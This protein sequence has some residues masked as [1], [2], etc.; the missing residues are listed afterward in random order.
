[1]AV[2]LR[3]QWRARG[4]ESSLACAA[5]RGPRCLAR[6]TGNDL[7]AECRRPA[8]GPM[9]GPQRLCG[10]GSLRGWVD[11]R[12]EDIRFE[13]ELE[14]AEEAWRKAGRDRDQL[15]RGGRLEEAIQDR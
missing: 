11:K 7:R 13:R 10:W 2:G 5:A 3:L 12:R 15:L 8:Q 6:Q 14:H 9:G 1:M 4:L